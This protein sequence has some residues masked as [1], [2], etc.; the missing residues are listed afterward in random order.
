MNLRILKNKNFALLM[1]GKGVSMVGSNMQQ[2]TLS[3]YVLAETGSATIFASMMAISI[4]PRLVLSPVA[5]VFGDWFDRKKSIVTLDLFNGILIGGF[6]ILY[7]VNG[8]L[9]LASIYVLVIL[10]EITEIFFGAAMSAV[11]PSIVDE[12]QLFEANSV[13]SVI[14]SGAN[15]LSPLIAA[16]L[17]AFAGLLV[18]FIINSISFILSALSELLI[19]IPCTNKKPDKINLGAFKTDLLQGVNLIK[20]HKIIMNI[21]GL[22]MILNFC[23]APLF[24]VVLLF[25]IRETLVGSEI[26]YGFFAASVSFSML[27]SPM[28]LG[29]I[30]KKIKVG[31]LLVYVFSIVAVFI[32]L[33]SFATSKSFI[34]LYETNN[35]PIL[36][37]TLLTFTM[38]MIVSLANIGLGT[39]FDTVVPRQFMGRV[40]TTMNLG[41]TIAMPLGQMLFGI[42]LDLFPASYVI[43]FAS[44]IILLAVLYYQKPLLKADQSPIKV[45]DTEL[46]ESFAT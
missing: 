39:L 27:L 28:L 17:Y 43:A 37:V 31:K 22:G 13:K 1:L 19:E 4:L 8:G 34:G 40:G 41:L 24:S 36:V 11:I 33:L 5:G 9:S 42:A 32:L 25:V 21:I 15:M 16:T 29:G 20:K 30:A 12:E 7:S 26:Q 10:L 35:V 3:L 14:L 44:G 18:I 46:N 45:E 6:A 23:F 2:F 38:A